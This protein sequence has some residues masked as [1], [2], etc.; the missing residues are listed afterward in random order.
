MLGETLASK[1]LKTGVRVKTGTI[2]R[3]EGDSS[4]HFKCV[5]EDGTG[6]GSLCLPVDLQQSTKERAREIYD[7]IRPDDTFGTVLERF[8][9]YSN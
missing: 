4:E 8:G 7:D 6:T 2:V 9:N 5:I 3:P 1:T